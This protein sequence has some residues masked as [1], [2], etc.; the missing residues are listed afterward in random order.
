[1]STGS[2]RVVR[3][4]HTEWQSKA[5]RPARTFGPPLCA[6]SEQACIFGCKTKQ[7]NRKRQKNS[8]ETS[9]WQ[10]KRVADILRA[11]CSSSEIFLIR[12]ILKNFIEFQNR[13]TTVRHLIAGGVCC[14]IS[15]YLEKLI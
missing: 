11:P 10:L 6:A 15:V 7:K 4:R 2:E 12:K 8:Y 5:A 14:A 13:L 3:R 1:M 9:S